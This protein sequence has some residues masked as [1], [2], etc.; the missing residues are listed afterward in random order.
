MAS[1]VS[2]TPLNFKLH[3]QDKAITNSAL[4][5]QKITAATPPEELAFQSS[6]RPSSAAFH[7][8]FKPSFLTRSPSP[9]STLVVSASADPVDK[10]S[11]APQALNELPLSLNSQAP[12]QLQSVSSEKPPTITVAPP[13]LLKPSDADEDPLNFSFLNAPSTPKFFEKKSFSSRMS[14]LAQN[15][16]LQVEKW[17]PPKNSTQGSSPNPKKRRD[18][19]Y[20]FRNLLATTVP[21]DDTREVTPRKTLFVR[22]KLKKEKPEITTLFPTKVSEYETS[23]FTAGISTFQSCAYKPSSQ[24]MSH[25]I[26]QQKNKKG[27]GGAAALMVLLDHYQR[28]RSADTLASLT[29]EQSFLTWATTAELTRTDAMALYLKNQGLTPVISKFS[30]A[31]TEESS[32]TNSD[33]ILEKT[34]PVKNSKELVTQVKNLL[35]ETHK[36]MI[37]GIRHPQ[38]EGHWIVV[39]EFSQNSTDAGVFH[40]RDPFTC[41]AYVL[42]EKELEDDVLVDYSVENSLYFS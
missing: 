15:T 32:T 10:S 1:T 2:P 26:V 17:S 23:P 35:A 5:L 9:I 3:D 19:S 27:C 41:S 30:K 25:T 12:E 28:T 18:T 38:I 29:V 4:A 7:G 42:T 14:R 21:S 20:L 16:F 36:S 22:K 40:I 8:S 13:V 33:G 6:I 24:S 39:D 11:S 31:V 37:L 34:I